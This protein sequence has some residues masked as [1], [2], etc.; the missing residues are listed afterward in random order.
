MFGCPFLPIDHPGLFQQHLLHVMGTFQSHVHRHL[1]FKQQAV[2]L[3]PLSGQITS[4][5]HDGYC[6]SSHLLP[7]LHFKDQF[8]HAFC[9][10]LV[11]L[12]IHTPSAQ[13]SVATVDSS[14][15]TSKSL[16]SRKKRWRNQL[17][18]ACCCRRLLRPFQPL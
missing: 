17:L 2:P 8:F 12:P 14:S 15:S 13:E 1:F 9:C 16:T 6:K 5:A 10:S 3:W 7:S 18:L 11:P 4:F